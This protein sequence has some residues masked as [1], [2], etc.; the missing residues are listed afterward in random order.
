[1]VICT[2]AG[3]GHPYHWNRVHTIM[4]QN[5]KFLPVGYTFDDVLLVPQE[6]DVLPKDID[7]SSQLTP[8]IRLSIPLVS[9]AMD[10]V[11]EAALAIALA[12]EGG[13]GFIH[14]NIPIEEQASQVDIVKRSENGVIEDPITLSP[15]NMIEEAEQLMAKYRISGIPITQNGKLVGIITNRDLRFRRSSKAKIGTLMTKE[16]LITAPVGTT[17]EEAK[18][19]LH[20]NRIEKLP[21]VD[22]HF[23][24]R[25]LI[26]IKDIQKIIQYP[27]SCKDA[28]GRL[29]VGAAVGVTP[30]AL[31]R[32][33][34]LVKAG[35]DV[36]AVDSAHG[37]SKGVINLVKKIKSRFPSLEVVAGNVATAEGTAAL[38]KAGADAVKV[39]MGPG[40]ICTTRIVAGTGVPQLTAIYQCAQEANKYN[41]PIIADGGIK[42]SGDITKALAAGASSVMI[43][44]LFAGTEES[45]GE[46]IYYEGKKYKS[47]RGMG[48]MA[49][50]RE[51]SR[52]RYFQ[53][54]SQ[55]EIFYQERR[56]RMDKMVPEGVEG[57][58]IYKGLL[59][60]VTFQLIGGLRAGMGYCGARNIRELQQ[61]AKFIPITHAGLI[62]SHVHDVIIT[63]EAPNYRG[64]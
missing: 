40:S 55:E 50:M 17:L 51:G 8:R 22:E 3:R 41:I 61:K 2:G 14:K 53:D 18:E 5:E 30:N 56:E 54:E 43:G 47:Y 15:D 32:V 59:S 57:R 36:I 1:M 39:G 24:L 52:D 62:E 28:M 34:A 58:V 9:S 13:I 44:S 45:P 16:N 11:T 33:E 46:V 38:I 49:A 21:L 12:R 37:H 20:R 4:E 6:S 31:E 23:N 7:V 48:S 19:I 25:G 29:R 27:N 42:H 64:R 35:V 60:E 63:K 10:T 26:T